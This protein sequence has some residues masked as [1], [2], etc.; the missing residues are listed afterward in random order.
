M[1][2]RKVHRL[3]IVIAFITLWWATFFA[4]LG[5]GHKVGA[6]ASLALSLAAFVVAIATDPDA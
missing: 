2:A 1:S 4:L 5:P 3:A 6:G